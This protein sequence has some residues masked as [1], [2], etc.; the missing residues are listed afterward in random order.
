[1]RLCVL[2]KFKFSHL[3]VEPSSYNSRNAGI[4]LYGMVAFAKAMDLST[5]PRSLSHTNTST[6]T[7]KLSRRN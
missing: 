1:M 5:G 2:Y 6:S 7:P 3:F 4:P